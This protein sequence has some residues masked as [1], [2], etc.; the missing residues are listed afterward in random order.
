MP[1]KFKESKENQ[2]DLMMPSTID[3]RD[4]DDLDVVCVE[5]FSWSRTATKGHCDEDRV[6]TDMKKLNSG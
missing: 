5:R 3:I 1:W 2:G 6:T 4:P